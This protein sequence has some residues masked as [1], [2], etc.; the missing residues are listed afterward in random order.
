MT[1]APTYITGGSSNES[2]AAIAGIVIGM[3][4]GMLLVLTLSLKACNYL[5]TREGPCC[6]S[7]KAKALRRQKRRQRRAA[8][9]RASSFSSKRSTP[10]WAGATASSSGA[11]STSGASSGAAERGFFRDA[12]GSADD[13]ATRARPALSELNADAASLGSCSQSHGGAPDDAATD[14]G[15][16]ARA[17]PAH[18]LDAVAPG[19]ASAPAPAPENPLPYLPQLAQERDLALA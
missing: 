4:A 10:T 3:F 13:G 6:E 17:T 15:A 8:R 19:P 2:G 7:S 16:A 11:S 1:P 9:R 14:G 12:G 18:S 5:E